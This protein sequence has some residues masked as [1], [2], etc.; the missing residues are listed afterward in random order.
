MGCDDCRLVG[1]AGILLAPISLC[2]LVARKVVMGV[3]LALA[4]LEEKNL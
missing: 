2:L 1:W 4:V 3:V